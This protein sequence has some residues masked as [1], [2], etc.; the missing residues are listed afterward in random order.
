MGAV[1]L[2]QEDGWL[3]GWLAS[4]PAGRLVWL[5][6]ETDH[7][8]R[9]RGAGA[10]GAMSLP[11]M[12][13]CSLLRGQRPCLLVSRQEGAQFRHGGFTDA[14]RLVNISYDP[15]LHKHQLLVPKPTSCLPCLP[16]KALAL[17]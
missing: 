17:L 14:V 6:W 5:M 11:G 16:S 3:A 8:S 4:W 1:A 7:D 2:V 15:V 12:G 13:G 10:N 9:Q